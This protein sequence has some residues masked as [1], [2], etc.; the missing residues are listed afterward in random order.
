LELIINSLKQFLRQSGAIAMKRN[1]QKKN[2]QTILNFNQRFLDFEKYLRS[3][4]VHSGIFYVPKRHYEAT[5]WFL[6]YVSFDFLSSLMAHPSMDALMDL[7]N[8]KGLAFELLVNQDPSFTFEDL[9]LFVQKDP[10]KLKV[11]FNEKISHFIQIYYKTGLSYQVL[12][13]ILS[14]HFDLIDKFSDALQR[15]YETVNW[16]L[17]YVSFDFLASLI[18]HPSMDALMDLMKEKRFLFGFLVSQDPRFTFKDLWLFVQRDSGKLK[19]F[20]NEKIDQFI[21]IHYKTGLSYQ[22]LCSI[23]S[24]H[25]DSIDRFSDCIIEQYKKIKDSFTALGF[26]EST[27]FNIL[28]LSGRRI[29][30]NINVLC[31]LL[32]KFQP[33][34]LKLIINSLAQGRNRYG[35]ARGY[36]L[37]QTL[38]WM[39]H[40]QRDLLILNEEQLCDLLDVL[41][42]TNLRDFNML[43]ILNDRLIHLVLQQRLLQQS[44]INVMALYRYEPNQWQWIPWGEVNHDTVVYQDNKGMFFVTSTGNSM[45]QNSQHLQRN[46]QFQPPPYNW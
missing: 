17:E 3:N 4:N 8:K 29:E 31:E 6:K 35:H 28:H 25:L 22:V 21:Q 34:K 13:S 39:R 33:P 41:S 40:H 11:F 18:R 20:F 10:E 7:M 36:V 9:W 24:P 42:S 12:C 38:G 19:V 45:H 46:E 14:P 23:L 16:F 37:C 1:R 43:N 32:E 5:N 27:L 44:L 30:E 26:Y 2:K 15:H